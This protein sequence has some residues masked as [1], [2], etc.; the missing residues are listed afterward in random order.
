M[1]HELVF[2]EGAIDDLAGLR[3]FDRATILQA[4]ETHLRH[5]PTRTSKSRVKRLRDSDSPQYRLRVD[6]FRIFYDVVQADVEIIAVIRK[7]EAAA[8]LAARG[9]ST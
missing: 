4:V 5:E 1:R 8:W 6:D 7:S 9:G 2:D 3:A